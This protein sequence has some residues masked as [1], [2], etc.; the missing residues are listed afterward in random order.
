[1][2]APPQIRSTVPPLVQTKCPLSP[3]ASNTN[4][5][6]VRGQDQGHS[7]PSL[8][9]QTLWVCTVALLPA[10][11]INE[12]P[13][14]STTV[15]HRGTLQTNF[16]CCK[17]GVKFVTEVRRNRENSFNHR[18]SECA[19]KLTFI[20]SLWQTSFLR[21]IKIFGVLTNLILLNLLL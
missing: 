18:L 3:A 17:L 4:E 15:G 20:K 12:Q 1:M 8:R 10:L 5:S 21:K 6:S 19:P 7:H 13:L 11:H 16:Y 14:S 9:P 2:A